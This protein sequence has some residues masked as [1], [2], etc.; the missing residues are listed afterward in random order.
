MTRSF[1][2]AAGLVIAGLRF[3]ATTKIV[4]SMIV[5]LAFAA[6][7]ILLTLPS[8]AGDLT[9]R[10]QLNGLSP[11]ERSVTVVVSPERRPTEAERKK[12]DATVR[13]QLSI[14]GYGAITRVTSFRALSSPQ[15]SLYRL[16]AT[17]KIKSA[18]RL[19]SGRWPA[20]CSATLCEVVSVGAASVKRSGRGVG[21][22]DLPDV[23]YLRVVGRAT[24]GPTF[25]FVGALAPSVGEL[26]VVADGPDQVQD[27]VALR[28]IRRVNGWIAPIEPSDVSRK[29]VASVLNGAARISEEID[30]SGVSVSVPSDELND[31]VSRSES[32]TRTLAI[33]GAQLLALLTVGCAVGGFALRQNHLLAYDR[34]KRRGADRSTLVW[35]T[36]LSGLIVLFFG[37]ILGVLIGVGGAAMIARSARVSIVDMLRVLIQVR[38]VLTMA[39]AVVV[40]LGAVLAAMTDRANRPI[41][42]FGRIRLSDVVALVAVA[43]GGLGAVAATRNA[44]RAT[45]GF[46]E[47]VAGAST[48]WWWPIAV[49]AALV[50]LV[51]RLLPGLLRVIS[52]LRNRSG[53]AT[54]VSSLLGTRSVSRQRVSLTSAALAA[55]ESAVCVFAIGTQATLARSTTDQAG[56][57]VPLQLRLRIGSSLVRPDELRSS[58]VWQSIAGNVVDTDVVRRGVTILGGSGDGAAEVLGV[59]PKVFRAAP[60]WRS[61]YGPKNIS[62][63]LRTSKPD[64]IGSVIDRSATALLVKVSGERRV[65]DIAAVVQ[66]TN[67]TWH[68]LLLKELEVNDKAN[69]EANDDPNTLRSV[70]EPGDAGG[71]LLG[72]RVGLNG[73]FAEQIEHKIGEGN[74]FNGESSVSIE[75]G[76]AKSLP[77]GR[78]INLDSATLASSQ[79]VLRPASTGSVQV[80]LALQGASA[81][82]LPDRKAD[83]IPAVVDQTT[84]GIA[85]GVGETFFVETLQRRMAFRVAG[86]ASRFPTMGGRF[87][88]A[89]V[90][91]VA[92]QFNLAQPGF[93]TPTEAWVSSSNPSAL[94]SAFNAAPLN[95]LVIDDRA[96]IVTQLRSDP[97]RRMSVAVLFAAAIIGAIVTAIGL[98]ISALTDNTDQ[99]HFRRTLRLEGTSEG[100][101]QRTIGSRTLLSAVLP[102][103][104]GCL[105]GVLLLRLTAH[106]VGAGAYNAI[107]GLPLRYPVPLALV[108][109]AIAGLAIVF[110]FSSHLGARGVAPLDEADLLRGRS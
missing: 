106:D 37:S 56:F 23:A 104:I 2:V 13:K 85:G 53:K 103:P 70:L 88:V 95:Q 45:T 72:Y 15:G 77:G 3:R 55:V 59:D 97:L 33:A 67:G 11:S 61:D 25:P 18:L 98:A 90:G 50:W 75:I 19:T 100:S 36:L 26:L 12:F 28:L 5:A 69:D 89:D 48:S 93:G 42:R 20:K 78:R 43:L 4:A 63:R 21:S 107:D 64:P 1:R 16:V 76:W 39:L 109:L 40:V 96:A 87:V 74:A 57:A 108:S 38:S 83:P 65:L 91:Q 34:L 24:A 27:V 73:F 82:I 44:N 80:R 29:S 84:A 68:E 51:W 30:I 99:N 32:S 31:A 81:L 66:R 105:L 47:P 58:T 62:A 49:T 46:D 79:A 92:R 10:H 22:V 7:L 54:S 41:A 52:A 102:L 94:R 6:L 101:I 86:V 110:A 9:V 8:V 71:R 17:E 35:F 14:T 60:H